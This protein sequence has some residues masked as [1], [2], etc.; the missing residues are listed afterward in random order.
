MIHFVIPPFQ[1]FFSLA[2]FSRI[3]GDIKGLAGR[4]FSLFL[5]P[6]SLSDHVDVDVDVHIE[7]YFT[8]DTRVSLSTA[9]ELQCEWSKQVRYRVWYYPQEPNLH[10]SLCTLAMH[11]AVLKC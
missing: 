11:V 4:V 8:H 1:I 2:L 7:N 9:H 3:Q 6:S 5:F 10:L